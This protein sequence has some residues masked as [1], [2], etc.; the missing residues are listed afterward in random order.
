[1]I[2]IHNRYLISRTAFLHSTDWLMIGFVNE[3]APPRVRGQQG[4]CVQ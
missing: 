2:I 3:I 1:M 4:Q